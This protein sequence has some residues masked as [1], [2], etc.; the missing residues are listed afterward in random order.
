MDKEKGIEILRKDFWKRISPDTFACNVEGSNLG[1]YSS[2][3][4]IYVGVKQS[5][6][7]RQYDPAGHK[8]HSK[9]YYPNIVKYDEVSKRY[10]EEEISRISFSFQQIILTKQLTALCG[11]PTKFRLPIAEQTETHEK[12][13]SEWKEG[14]SVKDMDILIHNA[15]ESI[16]KTGDVAVYMYLNKGKL[17]HKVFSFDKGDLLFP[18]Y[19]DQGKLELFA[20]KYNGLNEYGEAEARLD[21]FTKDYTYKLKESEG[22]TE[23]PIWFINGKYKVTDYV[24]MQLP[25]KHGLNFCPIA[26]YRDDKG[27]WWTDS[28]KTIEEFEWAFSCLTHSNMAYAFPIMYIKGSE[29]EIEPDMIRNTVKA[30]FMPNKDSEAGFLNRPDGSSS[31]ELQLKKLYDMIYQQS[32]AVNPPEVRSG[33]LPGVA[34]KLLYSPSIEKASEMSKKLNPFLDTLVDM[35]TFFYGVEYNKLAEFKSLKIYAYLEPYVHQNDSEVVKNL[36][37]ARNSGFLS[38]K[39]ATEISSYSNNNEI[40]RLKEEQEEL[41]AQDLLEDMKFSIDAS[42]TETIK[43]DNKENKEEQ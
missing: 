8:V 19:D 10:Y 23:A 2:D 9:D 35:F 15:F 39:T 3:K 14:W 16:G 38:R 4:P 32:F 21:V 34:I 22:K 33:D 40:Q 36:E 11:N 13:F 37:T 24:M 12:L 29:V 18:H 20:R 41:N 30:I 31:F 7:L 28:Q 17:S 25:T 1:R 42:E 43:E 26:Y 5:E 27:A 6:F